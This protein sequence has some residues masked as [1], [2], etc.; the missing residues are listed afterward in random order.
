MEELLTR[1]SDA[2]RILLDWLNRPAVIYQAVLIVVLFALAYALSWWAEPRLRAQARRIRKMAGVLRLVVILFRRIVWI[3]YVA[4]LTTA[5][6]LV[7]SLG[8]LDGEILGTVLLLA[9]AW[10]VISVVSQVIRSRTVGRTF[11]FIGWV[12][13]A[14][15]IL[16]IASQISAVLDNIGF[17][18]GEEYRI[19]LL[20][21]LRAFLLIGIA[22]WLAFT[23]GNFL[24]QRIQRSRELTQNLRV[25]VGKVLRVSCS[26]SRASSRFRRS[27]ST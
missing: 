13:V 22:L 27:A 21:L 14:V 1:A 6:V 15:T 8:W 10:L 26:S 9:L 2:S 5:Y 7:R 3:F 16:G 17:G 4:F 19:T 11:A 25:L 24:D 12:Y 20:D 23:I 18:I